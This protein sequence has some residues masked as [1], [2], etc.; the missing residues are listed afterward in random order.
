MPRG[1]RK[2][3]SVEELVN[4]VQNSF[5][6]DAVLGNDPSLFMK[7]IP[8]GIFVLDRI[9]GGGFVRGKMHTLFGK[10]S[11]G[12]TTLAYFFIANAQKVIPNL[13]CAII[14]VE[15]RYE[16]EYPEKIGID[17]SKIEIYRP[18]YGEEAM[19]KIIQLVKENYDIVVLDSVAAIAPKAQI[20]TSVSDKFMGGKP[21]LLNQS[22]ENIIPSNNTTV[23]IL[24]NQLRHNIGSARNPGIDKT[25]PGGEGIYH[26][27]H[28]VAEISRE[29]WITPG[30]KKESVGF[31]I[32]FFV[33]EKSTICVPMKECII[34]FNFEEAKID[35]TSATIDLAIEKGLIKDS[36]PWYKY[37]D[38]ESM[39]GKQKVI[40]WFNENLD[41]L[42]YLKEEMLK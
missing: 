24:L 41:E 10:Y 4:N 31:N 38:N 34:P 8:T 40:D 22:F 15:H 23:L 28:L 19:D 11:Q 16:P 1:K 18:A 35:D 32:R 5:S 3:K 17:T 9:L 21:R 6:K 30:T 2:N 12:K 27:S 14:D 39:M 33:T 25:M 29:G 37:K 42:D 13:K 7:R 36:S 26:F 20:E